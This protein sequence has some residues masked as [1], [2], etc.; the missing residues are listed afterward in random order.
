MKLLGFKVGAGK[1]G[2]GIRGRNLMLPAMINSLLLVTL[3][4]ELYKL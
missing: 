2:A 4:S 3:C 1:L